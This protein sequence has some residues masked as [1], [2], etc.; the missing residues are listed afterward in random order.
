[1]NYDINKKKKAKIHQNFISM[2]KISLKET[3]KFATQ[4]INMQQHSENTS[5]IQILE[6]HS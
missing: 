1:M 5:R 6:L 3:S 2:K 4:G